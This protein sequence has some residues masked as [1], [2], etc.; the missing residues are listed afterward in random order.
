MRQNEYTVG[1]PDVLSMPSSL[2]FI[3]LISVVIAAWNNALHLAPARLRDAVVN[4]G[5]TSAALT[6]GVWLS[7]RIDLSNGWLRAI[8]WAGLVAVVGLIVVAVARWAPRVGRSLADERMVGMSRARFLAHAFL[9]IPLVSGLAEEILFRG[10]M[11]ALLSPLL[12][13]IGTLVATSAAFGLWHVVVSAQQARRM[14]VAPPRWVAL[15]VAATLGAGLLLGGLRMA[16]GGVWAPAAVH[17]AVN[18]TFAVAARVG[19]THT[20]AEPAPATA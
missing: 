11:W 15:N 2:F 17:A 1:R 8:P 10:V 4:A 7:T 3:A 5:V 12:G 14:G 20:P 6:G 13:P 16:T 9:R 19:A 18:V